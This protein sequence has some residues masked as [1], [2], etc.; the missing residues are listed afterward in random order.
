MNNAPAFIHTPSCR[1]F[2]CLCNF[3]DCTFP[4]TDPGFGF[5][6]GSYVKNT[7]QTASVDK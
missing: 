2:G 6:Y 1:L 4:D 5:E 3:G 7:T